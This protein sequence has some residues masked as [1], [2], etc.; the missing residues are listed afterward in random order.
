MLAVGRFIGCFNIHFI[1]RC[2]QYLHALQD[3]FDHVLVAMILGAEFN[4]VIQK[5]NVQGLP[6]TVFQVFKIYTLERSGEI[7][8]VGGLLS[9]LI[10][11]VTRDR[12]KGVARLMRC[13]SCSSAIKYWN[14]RR[15][16][17]ALGNELVG[18][19]TLV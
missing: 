10:G 2:T 9:I 7:T 17:I 4:I 13:A 11:G 5:K 18:Y 8:A 1:K 14:W 16:L 15:N 12:A 3:H 19:V 6:F